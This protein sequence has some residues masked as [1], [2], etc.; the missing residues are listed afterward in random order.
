MRIG[1][2]QAE[3]HDRRCPHWRT[4]R[5]ARRLV[6]S[7]AAPAVDRG[8]RGAGRIVVALLIGSLYPFRFRFPGWRW[9]TLLLRNLRHCGRA[10][11]ACSANMLLF[12]AVVAVRGGPDAARP[13][14]TPRRCCSGSPRTRC[15]CRCTSSGCR[16]RSPRSATCSGIARIAAA[17]TLAMRLHRCAAHRLHRDPRG[18][19]CS[20]C[21]RCCRSGRPACRSPGCVRCGRR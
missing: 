15:C 11:A 21:C 5:A 18:S 2:T 6:K 17:G 14:A 4:R 8:A 19:G 10:R 7:A 9:K 12:K 1:R 3:N 16:T 13:G 20:A